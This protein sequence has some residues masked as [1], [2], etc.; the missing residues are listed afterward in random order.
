[1]GKLI[2][3]IKETYDHKACLEIASSGC[4]NGACTRHTYQAETL[5]L[6][7]SYSDEIIKYISEK[8]G[9][10]FLSNLARDFGSPLEEN[11]AEE[12]FT[13]RE[14]VSACPNKDDYKHALVWKFIELVAKEKTL[15]H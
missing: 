14:V 3:L 6:Y 11:K 5:L 9:Y 2:D 10:S 7:M 1:M 8:L 4:S 13:W 15:E 12:D